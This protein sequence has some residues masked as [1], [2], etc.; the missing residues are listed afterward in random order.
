ME[1]LNH[2]MKIRLDTD[3]DIIGF[4]S[5]A[6]S[7]PEDVQLF[8]VNNAG[9]VRVEARSVLGIT[10]INTFKHLWLISNSD[11]IHTFFSAFSKE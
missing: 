10:Y 1:E 2:R 7:L 3:S 8:V 9:N 4:I 5:K 11:K 6:E